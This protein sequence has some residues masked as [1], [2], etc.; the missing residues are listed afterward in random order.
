[1]NDKKKL[2]YQVKSN[3]Q[4]AYNCEMIEGRNKITQFAFTLIIC[5]IKQVLSDAVVI[6]TIF[7]SIF[8]LILIKKLTL[9][10]KQYVIFFFLNIYFRNANCQ[11]TFSTLSFLIKK[12][13]KRPNRLWCN[14]YINLQNKLKKEREKKLSQKYATRDKLQKIV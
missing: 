4:Y 11:R 6:Q 3:G 7:L 8:F 13:E 5:F 1:M 12:M 2:K 14:A 10:A 9:F